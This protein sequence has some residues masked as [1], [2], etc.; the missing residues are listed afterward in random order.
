MDENPRHVIEYASPDSA[1]V[2]PQE[3]PAFVLGVIA[4]CF[5]AASII[6]F[7]WAR[8]S[9]LVLLAPV[10][11][12]LGLVAGGVGW[13]LSRHSRPNRSHRLCAWVNVLNWTVFGGT[14]AILVVYNYN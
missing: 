9:Y 6:I 1:R 2:N 10:V 11:N 8:L 5:C 3:P 12:L 13:G 7:L 14:I 4:T